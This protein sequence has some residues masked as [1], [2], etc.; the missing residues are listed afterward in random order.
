MNEE[1]KEK[2]KNYIFRKQK[3]KTQNSTLSPIWT[4]IKINMMFFK[5]SHIFSIFC[6]F[7]LYSIIFL[8]SFPALSS[9]CL[10]PS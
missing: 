7:L 8:S 10:K 6:H 1:E 2:N 4:I 9:Q 3:Y 5:K